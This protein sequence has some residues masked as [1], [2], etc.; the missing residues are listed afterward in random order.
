MDYTAAPRNILLASKNWNDLFSF[1]AWDTVGAFFS[2]KA[3]TTIEGENVE[4]ESGTELVSTKDRYVRFAQAIEILNQIDTD[5]YVLENGDKLSY[6]VNID[7]VS[8]SAFP[9]IFSTKRANLFI[10]NKNSPAISLKYAIKNTSQQTQFTGTKDNSIGGIEFPKQTALGRYVPQGAD[11]SSAIT[12]AGGTWGK[13]EDLYI[14]FDFF[15]GIIEKPNVPIKEMLYQMLNG[16]SDAA[17]GIWDFQIYQTKIGGKVVITVEDTNL[18]S[19]GSVQKPAVFDISGKDSPFIST[20]FN[21]DMSGKMLNKV[22]SE[23]LG[24]KT[25]T[26]GTTVK[27]AV[28]TK[29]Q[30]LVVTSMNIT[31]KAVAKKQTDPTAGIKEEEVE[32]KKAENLARFLE[33]AAIV[34]KPKYN[35]TQ[36][37]KETDFDKCAIVVAY[38][39]MALFESLK[40]RNENKVIDVSKSQVGVLTNI[41]FGFT[42]H[43]ISGIRRGDMFKINGSPYGYVSNGFFQVTNIKHSVSNNFWQTEVKGGFRAQRP[44]K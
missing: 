11:G 6:R 3:T 28:G 37:E 23:R 30:D 27:D 17:G 34:P 22:V 14:N 29:A 42:I 35:K 16:M 38:D 1:A 8:I 2:G 5:G 36:V 20:T 31:P 21:M 10:P 24:K 12:R 25:D 7:G 44:I 9:K 18:L 15:K 41:E 39:D 4:L 40:M 43:G 26:T 19:N 13:L 33:K 32:Q